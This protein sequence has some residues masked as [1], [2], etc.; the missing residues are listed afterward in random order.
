MN[1]V[2]YLLAG[3]ASLIS[4]NPA[5]VYAQSDEKLGWEVAAELG[6]I[7]TSGNTETTSIQ[8]KISATQRLAYWHNE[9]IFS[10]LFKEDQV[11]ADDGTKTT[12]K[13]AEKYFLSAKSAYQLQQEHSNLFVYGS[14][15][16]DEFGAYSEYST[17]SVGYGTRLYNA[18]TMQ[19]DI[20]IGPGYFQGE[21]VLD[22][23]TVQDESGVI[24]RGAASYAWQISEAAEFKQTLSVESGDDNTRTIA[25]T[26][27]TTRINNSLQMKVGFDVANDSKVTEGKENTDTTTYVNLV[28]KF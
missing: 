28:Y 23:D 8:G 15:A 6:V 7:A 10:T 21:R 20:E 19:L 18:D 11:T 5:L 12:E 2:T 22:N 3:A 4:L 14:H 16:E 9:Y 13:T 17:L 25:E 27:L 24:L 26:S 1:K